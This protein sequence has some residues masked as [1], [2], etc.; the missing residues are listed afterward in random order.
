MSWYLVKIETD[1]LILK[2]MRLTQKKITLINTNRWYKLNLSD[3]SKLF[4]L[5]KKEN[6]NLFVAIF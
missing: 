6:L 5:K 2:K 4:K 1:I 3:N